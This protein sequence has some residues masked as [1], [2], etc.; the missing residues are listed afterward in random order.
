MKSQDLIV[1][2]LARRQGK[3]WEAFCLDFSLAA[4]GSTLDEAR[5]KLH[6]QIESYVRDALTVDREHAALLLQRKAPLRDRAIFWLLEMLDGLSNKAPSK[7]Y[8]EPIPM[9]PITA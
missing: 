4:Q 8:T 6:A 3:V 7:P 5:T 1:R 2:C 9:M